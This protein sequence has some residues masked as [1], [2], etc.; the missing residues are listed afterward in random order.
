MKKL[1]IAFVLLLACAWFALADNPH[2]P[3]GPVIIA[4]ASFLNQTAD[5]P[6]TTVFTPATTG[7]YRV[8]VYFE[9]VPQG[10][11]SC[12]TLDVFG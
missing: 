6:E 3:R 11:N 10:T 5:L 9:I 12:T 2:I 7:M 8:S 1:A 4:E